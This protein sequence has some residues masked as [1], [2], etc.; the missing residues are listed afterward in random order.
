MGVTIILSLIIDTRWRKG[1]SFCRK[2]KNDYLIC[3]HVFLNMR[4]KSSW[5]NMSLNCD[6]EEKTTQLSGLGISLLRRKLRSNTIS[7][8]LFQ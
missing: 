2:N 6:I 4:A 8:H 1:Q 7:L 5:H 3:V